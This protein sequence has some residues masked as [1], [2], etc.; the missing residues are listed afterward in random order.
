M[1]Q[2]AYN[3]VFP[4]LIISFIGCEYQFGI[5]P[6]GEGC[7]ASY[8]KCANGIPSEV[9]MTLPYSFDSVSVPGLLPARPGV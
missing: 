1:V 5:F 6:S 8:T 9:V 2:K 4:Q 7:F 3:Y